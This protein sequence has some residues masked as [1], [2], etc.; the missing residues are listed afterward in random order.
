[1]SATT[2]GMP[3]EAAILTSARAGGVSLSAHAPASASEILDASKPATG[4]NPSLSESPS[5]TT[6]PEAFANAETD[7]TID[8][9][10]LPTE[11]FTSM[12]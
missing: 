4:A 8:A 2:T 6:P 11:A 10:S 9:G 3:S 7:S 1:M 12:S 5:T